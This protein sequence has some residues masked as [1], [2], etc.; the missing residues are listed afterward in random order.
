MGTPWTSLERRRFTVE[1]Y[2]R[3]GEAGILSP[4]E[5]LELIDGEIVL[6]D[7]S[8]LGHQA[9]VD[10]INAALN[11]ALRSRGILRVKGPIRLDASSEPVPDLVV[12]RHRIDFYRTAHPTAR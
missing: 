2:Y 10:R 8:S 11:P 3:M 6:R 1:E 4:E 5:R 12:L 9:A 7:K